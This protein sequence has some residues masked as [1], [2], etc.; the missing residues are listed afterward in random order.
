MALLMVP[1]AVLLTL[2]LIPLNVTLLVTFW[3][4]TAKMNLKLSVISKERL[5]PIFRL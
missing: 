3:Q 4:S 1:K 2:V 5:I